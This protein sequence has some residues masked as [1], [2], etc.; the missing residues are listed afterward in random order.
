MLRKLLGSNGHAQ[1]LSTNFEAYKRRI[2]LLDKHFG[3]GWSRMVPRES[4]KYAYFAVCN[5][6]NIQ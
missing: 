4:R 2:V 3:Q 6:W 1:R 5:F